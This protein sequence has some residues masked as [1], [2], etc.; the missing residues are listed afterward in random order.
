MFALAATLQQKGALGMGEVSL[1]SPRS[2]LKLAMQ[3][4]WLFGTLSLLGGYVLQAMALNR[5]DLAV[6]QP[7][8]VTTIVF[9]LPLGYLLTHQIVSRRQVAAAGLVVL[10]L[11]TFTVVGTA[12]AGNDD[13]PGWE[14]AVTVGVIAILTAG[15]LLL[16]G[17]GS[18]ARK[19]A[20]YG[21]AAGILYGLSASLWKPA[22]A[23]IQADGLVGALTDWEFF[24]FGLAGILAFLV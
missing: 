3:P 9:A 23:V 7:L 17:R 21:A 19:A 15:L 16:G 2:F 5:G 4:F 22:Y 20:A 8:L 14:W 13:A 12:A 11:A 24:V 6:I 1:A 18:L 10:G